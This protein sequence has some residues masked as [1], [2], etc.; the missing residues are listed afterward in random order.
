MPTNALSILIVEDDDAIARIIEL[1]LSRAGFCCVRAATGD[2][3]EE[4]L[5]RQQWL[6]VILDRMLPGKSGMQL[7]RM[8]RADP[9]HAQTPVLMLTVLAQPCER[10]AGLAEGADDYL[11]KPF[12]PAELVLRVKAL[13][14]RRV[15]VEE[16]PSFVA[17]L[18]QL[19]EE[20]RC[21][22]HANGEAFLRPME[23]RLLQAL[24]DP[25]GKTR[26]R[27]WLLQRIWRGEDV[28]LR[29]VDATIR[30]LRKALEPLGLAQCI[31]T[32][33]G[34]GYRFRR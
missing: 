32:V 27:E 22:R 2:E 30:R 13:L 24:L 9:K 25:P 3:A 28:D 29:T 26:S 1:H 21:V 12:E 16:A 7:L 34:R 8:M 14:R 18:P 6:L 19:D 11:G 10:V 31:E 5:R 23:F 20:E 17:P 4:L 15:S 33:R